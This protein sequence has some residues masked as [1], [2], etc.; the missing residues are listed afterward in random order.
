MILAPGRPDL[1]P[2]PHWRLEAVVA[3][4]RPRSLTLGRDGRGVVFV[5]GVDT[6]DVWLVEVDGGA[7]RRLTTGRG[8]VAAAEDAPPALSPTGRLVAYVDAG[9]V[10]LA[11]VAGGPPRRLVEAGVPAW[12]DDDRLVVTVERER[13][14]RLA[15][16]D[17]DDP[18]PI[19]LARDPAAVAALGDEE[20]AAPS[21]DGAEVAYTFVPRDDLDRCELRVA[22]VATGAVRALVERAARSAAWSL[23]GARLAYVAER[24]GFDELHV[25][26]RDGSGDRQL[27]RAAADHED[28]RWHPDGRRLVAV[29]VRRHHRDLVVVDATTGATELVVAGGSWSRPQ[30]TAGGAIVAGFE[31]HDTAPELRLVD[32]EGRPSALHLPAPAAVRAAVHVAAEE[33]SF[34]AP[35]GL[36]I[37]SVVL[38][39]HS[40]SAQ[41]PA[42]AIVFPHSGPTDAYGDHWDGVAQYF[43]D[44]GYA[45]LAPNYRGSTGYG[46]AFARANHGGWGVADAGDCL[47]A[48]DF[49]R[50][51]DWIDPSRLAIF[52]FSYGAYL[53]LASVTDDPEHR[54]RCAAMLCGD[55]DLLTSWAQGD[56]VGA[57]DLERMMGHP[58]EHREAYR[59]GSPLHRV[60]NVDAPLLVAHG[61]RDERVSPRQSE[62]LVAELRRLG[63]PF[64][65]VTY[66][67]EGHGLLRA[68]PRL[69]FHR[70][71]ER[72]LDWHLL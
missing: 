44:K 70:R 60:A 57:Q 52:G 34:R 8:P 2:P 30:V 9:H 14:T 23:D 5:Q 32:A 17:V 67:T 37:P 16:M 41:E 31:A 25:V 50:T 4:E 35:D 58:S 56:R 22:D 1:D 42:A 39:P 68:G 19:R 45:W 53:A 51:Q 71:L 20:Q 46:S 61:E 28:A 3:T 36:E 11:P 12:L 24:D 54:Y 21:P 43:V 72:F 10:W 26:G 6:S 48:A 47:A 66:P 33:T 69:D 15:L 7:P 59:D 38:R 63:K 62:A 64:E 49:L 29:R 13:S 40:A 65:Y 55:C 27:T 18:W